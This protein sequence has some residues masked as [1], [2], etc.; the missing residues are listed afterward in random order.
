MTQFKLYVFIFIVLAS[1]FG[2]GAALSK[3]NK[4][5]IKPPKEPSLVEPFMKILR[6]GCKQIVG[7]TFHGLRDKCYDKMDEFES[8][9]LL[10][11]D[12]LGYQK[13]KTVSFVG[14]KFDELNGNVQKITSLPEKAEKKLLNFRDSSS[15]KIDSLVTKQLNKAETKIN[16][17]AR[18]LLNQAEQKS[19]NFV[20]STLD[21]VQMK[22]LGVTGKRDLKSLADE[23]MEVAE[24]RIDKISDKLMRK[25]LVVGGMLVGGFIFIFVSLTMLGCGLGGV[26]RGT[27]AF[28]V[29]KKIGL[30]D[31]E[32]DIPEIVPEERQSMKNNNNTL[33]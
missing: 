30:V 18:S 16:R 29:Q 33:V 15:S 7:N 8:Q 20:G 25:L 32:D 22:L 17:V 28:K 9:L 19:K 13:V 1:S 24:A 11:N 6:T 2:N 10:V 23:M 4:K 14:S 26:Q 12:W 5:I 3:S 21:D 27:L 31:E